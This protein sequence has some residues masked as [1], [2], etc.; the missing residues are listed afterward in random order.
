MRICHLPIIFLTTFLIASCSREPVQKF[1]CENFLTKFY[2]EVDV[3]QNE[4]REIYPPE[5]EHLQDIYKIT[6]H[7]EYTVHWE[8]PHEEWD[9]ETST[10]IP[11]GMTDLWYIN[12][13][14]G[15]IKRQ[16]PLEYEYKTMYYPRCASPLK[17]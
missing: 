9:E 16:Q 1:P 15:E 3:N 7:D 11:T 17:S 4:L 13:I 12:R 6:K 14:N 5:Y 10:N 2:L 8:T